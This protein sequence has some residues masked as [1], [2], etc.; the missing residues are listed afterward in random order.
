MRSCVRGGR[1]GAW[2]GNFEGESSFSRSLLFPRIWKAPSV[3]PSP[4]FLPIAG[5]ADRRRIWDV[6]QKNGVARERERERE[7]LIEMSRFWNKYG[8][9]SWKG[10]DKMRLFLSEKESFISLGWQYEE[11]IMFETQETR[12]RVSVFHN[13]CSS[14][15][16][17][18]LA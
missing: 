16:Q 1:E 13:A 10:G 6:D 9:E 11:A 8:N 12:F 17:T 3:C 14:C 5:L 2:S 18:S 15:P 7:T 4:S